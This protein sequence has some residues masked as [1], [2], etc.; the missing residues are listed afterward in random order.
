MSK[1]TRDA[2]GIVYAQD[3]HYELVSEDD[4]EYVRRTCV[5][6][7]ETHTAHVRIREYVRVEYEYDYDFDGPYVVDSWEIRRTR[8][9]YGPCDGSC[10]KAINEGGELV[11]IPRELAAEIPVR[12]TF[13]QHARYRDG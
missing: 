6:L 11:P 7:V 13:W 9:E 1:E 8:Y 10:K 4:D 2:L 12:P 3:Q 5:C